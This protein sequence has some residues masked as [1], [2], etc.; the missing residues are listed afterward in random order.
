MFCVGVDLSGDVFVVD[1]FDWF[2]ELYKVMDV[3]LMLVVGVINGFV[4][5][6]GL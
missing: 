1:Y 3:F 5:G 4:I 6:V 2:I